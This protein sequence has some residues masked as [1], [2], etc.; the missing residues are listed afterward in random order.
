M[1][2]VRC[3]NA[4]KNRENKKK[5]KNY[6]KKKEEKKGEEEEEKEGEEKEEELDAQR[7][8]VVIGP[9]ALLFLFCFFF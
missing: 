5:K 3:E 6:K 9:L 7:Q 1:Q 4:S 2:D 8:Y